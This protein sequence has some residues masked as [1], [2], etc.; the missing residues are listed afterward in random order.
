MDTDG[1]EKFDKINSW[2]KRYSKTLL[3]S[4]GLH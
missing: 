3:V 4:L 1:R 2:D